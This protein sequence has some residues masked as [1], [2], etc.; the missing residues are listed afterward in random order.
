M[1]Q[2]TFS[3]IQLKS[4]TYIGSEKEVQVVQ[5]TSTGVVD[6][7]LRNS[8]VGEEGVGEALLDLV[9]NHARL[10][11]RHVWTTGSRFIKI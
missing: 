7:G 4:K 8:P 3:K 6:Q 5:Q 11:V 10:K 9:G 2:T 1:F